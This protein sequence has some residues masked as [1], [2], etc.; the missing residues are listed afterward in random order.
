VRQAQRA[1]A[2][3]EGWR[4]ELEKWAAAGSKLE[5][6][7][8]AVRQF[9]MSGEGVLM[10]LTYIAS[11]IASECREVLRPI[12]PVSLRPFIMK[13][14]HSSIWAVHHG[15][16]TTRHWIES[17]FWW[18]KMK[19]EIAQFVGQCKVC[20]MAK[21]LKPA[22]QGLLRGRRHSNAMNELCMDLVG[23]ISAATGHDKH[24]T[25]V[26]IFVAIDPFTHM[27]WLE[28]LEAKG[29]K[30]VFRAFV[31]RILLEEGAPRI[32]RCDNGTEF[33]NKML[34]DLCREMQTQ[35]QFS[36]AYWPQGNQC[37]RLNRYIGEALRCMTNTKSGRKQ[38]WFQ[39]VKF[40]EFAY[41]SSPIKG[42]RL[43]PFEAARGRLPRLVCDNPLLDAELPVEKSLDE[44]VKEMNSL[45]ELA[46]AELQKA[47]AETMA[48]NKQLQDLHRTEEEFAVGEV[49]MFYN[50]MVGAD[51]DPTKL[52]L[53]T[54]LYRV[55]ARQGDIYELRSIKYPD[56]T[57][58]AH[59]GQLIRFKGDP[60][61]NEFEEAYDEVAAAA[62]GQI[63]KAQQEEVSAWRQ[64]E[65]GRFIAFRL[66]GDPK[67]EIRCAE[68]LSTEE[69]EEGLIQL[70]YYLDGRRDSYND[71]EKPLSERRLRPEWFGVHDGNVY[72]RPTAS[73]IAS[74]R[75]EKREAKVARQDI[76]IVV[77]RWTL[78]TD[79]KVPGPACA[80]AEKK[81]RAE[82]ARDADARRVIE[83]R[84]A[85]NTI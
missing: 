44:H 47:K 33:K 3:C 20:Q 79:G 42:T 9:V 8:A 72:L 4:A 41:R 1:D 56:S 18:P 73:Q 13:N 45:M 85:L 84:Y 27:V 7:P 77:P 69:R 32:I 61:E 68:V 59:V 5:K 75:I 23:P 15:L 25:P 48:E 21:A 65:E 49:V 14:Y 71:F 16:R 10:R 58:R 55:E 74:G 70:W 64:I 66:K 52:R 51:G 50:R 28:C 54:Y 76:E 63:N 37:E 12:A 35:M 26:Y 31:H 82:A 17:R 24:R 46:K 62:D 43:T 60:D 67:S 11:D 2:E 19:E 6:K 53:R 36:P 22:N 40:V 78:Q 39:Y 38:D 80:K 57:R 34:N 29:G 81:L 83:E 30:D